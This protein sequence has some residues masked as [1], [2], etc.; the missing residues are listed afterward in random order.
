MVSTNNFSNTSYRLDFLGV[1]PQRTGS[2]W[3]QRLLKYHNG[4]CLPKGY[5]ETMFF[6]VYYEDDFSKYTSL[7]THHRDGQLCGEISPTYFDVDVVPLRVFKINS[8]C[9][10]I[11]NIRNPVSRSLSLYRHHL[12]RG[13]V[14][15]GFTE[16]IVQMPRIVDSGR[17]SRHIPRWIEV[18]GEDRV[19]FVLMDDIVDCPERVLSRLYNFLGVSEITMPKIGV[20]RIN[21]SSLPRCPLLA[22]FAAMTV[23]QLHAMGCHRVVQ[24]GKA[25]KLHNFFY[26]GGKAELGRVTQQEKVQLLE[27]HA[28]DIEYL[29]VLLNK[30]LSHWTKI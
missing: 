10:I 20:E 17:Y 26:T 15:P 8:E 2:T 11:I 9:K 24:F 23:T 21:E 7:F 3:L 29:T 4:L 27:A 12:S 22:K 19:H 18:F 6:D 1:G 14:K 25:L 28:E 5:H 13:R 30:D 16:A